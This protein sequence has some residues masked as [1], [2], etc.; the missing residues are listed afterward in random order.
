MKLLHVV[1]RDGTRLYRAMNQKQAQIHRDGRGTFSRAKARKRNSARWIH[2]RYKGS[3]SFES[4]ALDSIDAVIQSPEP[5]DEARLLSSFLGWLD[6]HFG[7]K[8][9]SV[10]IDYR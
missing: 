9:S 10:N 5:G 8:L 3:V 4:D 7:K 1:A 6:R 2:V